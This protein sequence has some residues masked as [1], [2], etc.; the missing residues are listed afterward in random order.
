MRSRLLKYSFNCLPLAQFNA[1]G[2]ADD[3]LS[4][5]T[6]PAGSP[7]ADLDEFLGLFRLIPN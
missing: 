3:D 4:A 2:V 1:S 7:A 5:P 6:S